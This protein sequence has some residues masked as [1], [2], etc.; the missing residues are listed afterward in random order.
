MSLLTLAKQAV[1][2]CNSLGATALNRAEDVKARGVTT[3]KVVSP[4]Q[5]SYKRAE[6]REYGLLSAK[7]DAFRD[8][9]RTQVNTPADNERVIKLGK[10]VERLADFGNCGE[11]SAVAYRYLVKNGGAGRVGYIEWVGGNHVFVV[12]GLNAMAKM[13]SEYT[14]EK[15]PTDWGRNAVWCDPWAKQC[16]ETYRDTLWKQ[17]T[18]AI[19]AKTQA[20]S[21]AGTSFSLKAVSY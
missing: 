13:T 12:L 1:E 18:T 3:F 21:S 20:G 7:F 9:L 16:F 19:F 10:L 11:L 2:H 8:G 17:K 5:V 15:A 14:S 4:T 6:A